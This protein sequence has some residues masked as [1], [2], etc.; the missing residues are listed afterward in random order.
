[1]PKFPRGQVPP[2][3]NNNPLIVRLVELINEAEID[4]ND[5]CD[6]AGISLTSVTSWRYRTNPSI[7]N[8]EAVLN[9]LGHRLVIEKLDD[10]P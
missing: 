10:V 7:V 6:R 2:P 9:V 5:L 3:I 1:M 8:L 4:G